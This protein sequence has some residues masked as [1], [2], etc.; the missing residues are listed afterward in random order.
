MPKKQLCTSAAP[1][2]F[3]GAGSRFWEP[4][5]VFGSRISGSRL[6]EPPLRGPFLGSAPESLERLFEAISHDY[7]KRT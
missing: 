7:I 6:R 1:E 4:G 3:S 5:A 2:P